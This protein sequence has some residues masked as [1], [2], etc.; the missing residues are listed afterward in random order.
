LRVGIGLA[1]LLCSSTGLLEVFRGHPGRDPHDTGGA[2]GSLIGGP[3]RSVL[4]TGGAAVVL[5]TV[6][7]VSL[8]VI[9]RT[10]V[11]HAVDGLVAGARWTAAATQSVAQWFTSLGSEPQDELEPEAEIKPK[12]TRKKP[13]ADAPFGEPEPEPEPR[14]VEVHV[15]AEP[16]AAGEQLAIDLGPAAEHENWK[17]PALSLLKC[18]KAAEVDVKA[19]EAEGH[20]LEDA[21]A[22]HGVQTR[23]VGLTVG[24]T[25]TRYEL[26]LGPGVKVAR[27]TS[28]H[29]DIAYAMASPDVRILA[30]IPGR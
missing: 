25:V 10:S 2:L 12:R 22:A 28:L 27:V 18:T 8:L 19:T 11:K 13:V 15:P 23:L 4:A 9:T 6:L 21:L 3:L 1:L 20:V 30:P 26:E 5:I 29:K 16:V 17:L 14:A 7:A 24:P